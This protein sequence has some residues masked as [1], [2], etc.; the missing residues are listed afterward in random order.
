MEVLFREYHGKSLVWKE[1]TY[2]NS[3]WIVDER[4]HCETEIIAVRND[5]RGEYV[6]CKNCGQTFRN[7]SQELHDHT[8]KEWTP[9]MCMDCKSLKVFARSTLEQNLNQDV[10]GQWIRDTRESVDLLCRN[11]N[12]SFPRIESPAAR[13]YCKH[14]GCNEDNITEIEDFFIKYPGAF[15]DMITV[16]RLLEMK[17]KRDGENKYKV[18]SKKGIYAFVNSHN[19]VSQFHVSARRYSWVFVY[20]KKYDKLFEF[21]GMSYEEFTGHYALS[22]DEYHYIKEKIAELYR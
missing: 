10:D 22:V 18:R 13:Q 5:N 19:I 14:T 8:H 17:C 21:Y 4:N 2:Q 9:A 7:G 15:D 12:Y 3:N 20:S 16:D 1:A 11:N 6:T